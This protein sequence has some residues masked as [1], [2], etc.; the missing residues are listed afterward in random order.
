MNWEGCLD[1]VRALTEQVI[2]ALAP[3]KL[4]DFAD[5]FADFSLGAG[6]C[7][8][9]KGPPSRVPPVRGW[10]PPWWPACSSKS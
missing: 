1:V 9:R 3:E 10:I 2:S 7:R 8:W 5:D 4:A 6:R